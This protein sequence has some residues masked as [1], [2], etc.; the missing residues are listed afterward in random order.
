MIERGVMMNNPLRPDPIVQPDSLLGLT[1]E[2]GEQIHV[3]PILAYTLWENYLS[4]AAREGETYKSIREHE[5][6]LYRLSN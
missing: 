4:R 1:R 2:F 5:P 3:S 6:E